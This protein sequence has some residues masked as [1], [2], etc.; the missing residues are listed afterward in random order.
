MLVPV[1]HPSFVTI[2]EVDAIAKEKPL[3]ISAAETDSIFPEEL[4]KT[5]N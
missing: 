1:A 2:E 5:F 3:L 4:I